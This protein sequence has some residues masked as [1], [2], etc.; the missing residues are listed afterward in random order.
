M[1]EDIRAMLQVLTDVENGVNRT[2][3]DR[4]VAFR[5]LIE[6]GRM[7]SYVRLLPLV[8]N[9]N[10]SPYQLNSHFPFESV[11]TTYLP[12]EIVLK[13][14]RQVGK[15]QSVAARGLILSTSIPHFSSLF[16]TPLYEQIRRFSTNYFRPFIEQSPLKHTWMDT[17]TENS[18][19]QRTFKNFSKCYF[20]F[21]LTSADRLRGLSISALYADESYRGDTTWVKTRSGPK[22]LKDVEAGEEVVSFLDNGQLVWRRVHKKSYHGY[23]RCYRLT[24]SNGDFLDATSETYVATDAGWVRVSKI[25]ENV[26]TRRFLP[27]VDLEVIS[28]DKVH[29]LVRIRSGFTFDIEEERARLHVNTFLD[30]NDSNIQIFTCSVLSRQVLDSPDEDSDDLSDVVSTAQAGYIQETSNSGLPVLRSDFWASCVSN[31]SLREKDRRTGKVFAAKLISIE[32][33]GEHDVFDLEVDE[34]HTLI[35]NNFA[36]GNCQ[37][38]DVSL[39]PV[40]KEA[41]SASKYRLSMYT[42]TPKTLDNTI[43]GLWLSSSQAEWCITC[44]ACHKMNVPSMFHDL[45]RMIGPLR[46]DIS[47][48]KPAVIC[49]S[50]KCGRPIQPRNGRWIHKI[51]DRR[52][53]FPGHHIPQIIMPMHYSSS[54]RWEELL[55]KQQGYGNYTIPQFYNEV[56]G[57]S[58]DMGAKLLTKT[59]L[60]AAAIL[61]WKND[62]LYGTGAL[63]HLGNYIVRVLGVDWGG[64]GTAKRGTDKKKAE[65]FTLSFTCAAVLGLRVDGKIDV[66]YG[67]RLLTP[68]DALEEARQIMRIYQM[69]D[70]HLMAHDYNGAGSLRETIAVQAGIPL[71]RVVPISYVRTGHQDIMTFHA[72]DEGHNRKFWLLDKARS[73]TLMCQCIKLGQIRTFQNDYINEENRGLLHDLLSLQEN[74]VETARGSDAYMVQRNPHFPDDF[75]HAVNFGACTL[76][77]ESKGWPDL[78]MIANLRLTVDQM[79]AISPTQVWG[80]AHAGRA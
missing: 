8:L 60:E 69:F 18:V 2:D 32:D 67:R 16:L 25:I 31:G 71:N 19:L 5:Q 30:R 28:L 74:K 79:S 24:T 23:R 53:D 35:V 4:I 26:A 47:L 49:A 36:A 68:H 75:A 56:L 11:F 57:E 52:E 55:A 15:S 72:P 9:L 73:L 39:L 14:A 42:G 45:E 29:N 38:L 50:S 58:Y 34:T 54:K 37:D 66:I 65:N 7:L 13:T 27:T 63:P 21:A 40:A 59:D 33:V 6:S 76:W 80:T 17:S 20:S 77:N 1:G 46:E 70:C 43:E 61:P 48:E 10:G 41:M 12:S 3:L 78:A 64:G 22:L 62:P 51:K 44:D